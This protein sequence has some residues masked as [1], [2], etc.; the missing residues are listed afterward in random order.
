MLELL[1]TLTIVEAVLV[2]AVLVWY[3]IRLRISLRNTAGLLAKTAF[4]VRAIETQAGAIGP[5]VLRI[6][7][8]LEELATVGPELVAA[9]DQSTDS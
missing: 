3:L 9:A 2:L 6:N 4:G 5:G 1:I 7:A 8:V